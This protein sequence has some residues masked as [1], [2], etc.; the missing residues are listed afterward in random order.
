MKKNKYKAKTNMT[1]NRV[2]GKWAALVSVVDKFGTS[3]L[4]DI[5]RRQKYFVAEKIN[6][7]VVGNDEGLG[8][9]DVEIYEA[10]MRLIA[11]YGGVVD[12]YLDGAH[13]IN[14]PAAKGIW[15]GIYA[16]LMS[17]LLAHS[18]K[19]S[20]NGKLNIN[21]VAAEKKEIISKEILLIS[22]KLDNVC[23]EIVA[24]KKAELR[25]VFIKEDID[26]E[27]FIGIMNKSAE[28]I[29]QASL[30]LFYD[31]YKKGIQGARAA[32]NNL[33]A[34]H[35]IN[36]YNEQ[37]K[38]EQDILRQIVVVQVA[39]LEEAITDGEATEEEGI[40]INTALDLLR[41]TY[42]RESREISRIDKIFGEI[43]ARSKTRAEL[44][45]DAEDEAEFA[46][47]MSEIVL[48]ENMPTTYEQLKEGLTAKQA[49]FAH[50][51]TAFL[52]EKLDALESRLKLQKA[53]FAKKEVSNLMQVVREAG[54]CFDAILKHHE[55]NKEELLACGDKEIVTGVAET[56]LIKI[57]SLNEA[58]EIFKQETDGVIALFSD[59]KIGHDTLK[60]NFLR[61]IAMG[62]F[63]IGRVYLAENF[64]KAQAFLTFED[65]AEKILAKTEA[66]LSKKI[67]AFKRDSFLFEIITFEEIMHYSVSR[68]R[69]S[70]ESCVKD[71]VAQVDDCHKRLGD[72]LTKYGI[73]RIRPV[74]HDMFN[75]KENEV[76]MAEQHEDFKKG[77]IIKTMN[78]GFRQG[79]SVIVRANVIAAK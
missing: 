39:A 75:P 46:F 76:L 32:L 64:T 41:E 11:A 73:E 22:Q 36:Y 56:I 27:R 43:A 20:D 45:P 58:A 49:D 65:K 26:Y 61:E 67:M 19:N 18:E 70:D 50:A 55:E 40:V 9:H 77:E 23:D 74:P 54:H 31:A 68:L 72:C 10:Y 8:A 14:S 59:T 33:S 30:A 52:K 51:A 71:F 63:E 5:L 62:L 25:E 79:D 24:G 1:E 69:E 7:Q 12:I 17:R 16:V 60:D 28:D 66:S 53:Y 44:V 34:R 37:L 15:D 47:G 13:P 4:M 21:P 35:D 2:L 48:F 78:A 57:E 38:E 42:Q 6:T 29:R 3:L